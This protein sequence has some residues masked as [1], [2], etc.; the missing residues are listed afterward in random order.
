V[1]GVFDSRYLSDDIV[2]FR[3]GLGNIETKMRRRK[4]GVV[5][6]SS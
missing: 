4:R 6:I 1:Q 5:D 3:L 2:K